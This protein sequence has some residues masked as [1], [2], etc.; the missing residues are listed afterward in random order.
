MNLSDSLNLGCMC[1][2]LDPA[3]LRDQL[4]TD[5]RLAGLAD[6]L[7]RTHPHLFSQ[8]VVFLDPQT[9]DAVAHAVAA[10]ERVMS[11]PAWQEASLA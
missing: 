11:L 10:I 8:T 3:R 9:R 4:E 1:R 6:Q 2:T 7:D 5:P